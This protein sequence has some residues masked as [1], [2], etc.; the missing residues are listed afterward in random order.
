MLLT[1]LHARNELHPSKS[2]SLKKIIQAQWIADI[3][4]IEQDYSIDLNT[5]T[6]QKPGCPLSF[7]EAAGTLGVA[8]IIIVQ[9]LRP[10]DAQPNQ[11]AARVQQFGPSSIQLQAVG[12]QAEADV[13]ISSPVTI[14]KGEK[15]LEP[16]QAC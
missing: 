16:P 15:I 9:G 4:I 10:I 12:L 7:F 13:L 8:P 2:L 5:L 11:D 14:N 6:E 3:P 1:P